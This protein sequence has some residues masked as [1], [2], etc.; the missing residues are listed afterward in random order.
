MG[1][2][3]STLVP[4]TYPTLDE[5]IQGT[6]L[7]PLKHSI[8]AIG[9]LIKRISI[10]ISPDGE[11]LITHRD[12]DGAVHLD[13]L[14]A[15]YLESARRCTEELAGFSVRLAHVALE[16]QF[17]GIYKSAE[18]AL[19]RGIESGTVTMAKSHRPRCGICR[20]D[21]D[22]LILRNCRRG[23]ALLYKKE[24]YEAIW[25]DEPCCGG[26]F[27]E[28][29]GKRYKCLQASAKQVMNAMEHRPQICGSDPRIPIVI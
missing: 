22:V 21:T 9:Y 16:S 28:I 15:L 18:E 2:F 11:R 20:G 17:K 19:K 13:V 6:G 23:A 4:I 1:I 3:N 29:D 25:G 8:P 10:S 27:V 12:Y 5:M 14:G 26:G 24:E 7:L